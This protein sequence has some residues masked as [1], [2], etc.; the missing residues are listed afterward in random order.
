MQGWILVEPA[1]LKTDAKLGKWVQVAT[2]YA[3]SLPAK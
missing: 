1:G 2:K 3:S